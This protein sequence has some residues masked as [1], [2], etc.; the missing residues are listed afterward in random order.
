M[1]DKKY[2]VHVCRI[3]YGHITTTITASSPEAAAEEAI[4][5]AG[6]T[7]FSD[8]SSE[9]QVESITCVE[10][11]KVTSLVKNSDQIVAMRNE[12]KEE[13]RHSV[14]TA[15]EAREG[16]RLEFNAVWEDEAHNDIHAVSIEHGVEF[17]GDAYPISELGIEDSIYVLNELENN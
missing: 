17:E 3:G 16:K 9:Y 5:V 13:I 12:L 4:D 10:T 6:D 11:G 8:K 15:L 2:K 1:T 7:S 14:R